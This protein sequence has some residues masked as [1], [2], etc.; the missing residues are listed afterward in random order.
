MLYWLDE[1]NNKF[2]GDLQISVFDNMFSVQFLLLENNFFSGNIED[3]WKNKRSLIALDI[4]NNMISGKIPTWIGSLDGL[5]YVQMSRNRFAGELPI[6]SL[7][8]FSTYN[9]G[10]LSKSISW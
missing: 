6:Q 4:S 9:V 10:C 5:Q 3:A 1:S 8:P 7:L 2:S